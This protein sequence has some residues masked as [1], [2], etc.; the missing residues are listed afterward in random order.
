MKKGYIPVQLYIQN[1]TPSS[2][3]FSLDRIHLSLV[4][5]EEVADKAHTSTLGRVIGYTAAAIVFFPLA[6]PLAISAA[7]DGVKSSEANQ[8]LD[9][10][11]AMKS[12]SDQFIGKYSFMNKV[13]F[14]PKSEFLEHFSMTL[15]DQ[16]TKE[17]IQ[18]EVSVL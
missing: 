3:F 16:D 18:I 7:V 4:Q 5:P 1:N 15:I 13:V 17:P 9:Q 12:A 8:S 10:D 2:Y 14:V 6:L 11:F